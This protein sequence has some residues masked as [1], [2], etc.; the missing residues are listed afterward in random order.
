[1]T[2]RYRFAR[3]QDI[4]GLAA[5]RVL[6]DLQK[7]SLPVLSTSFGSGRGAWGASPTRDPTSRPHSRQKA[8]PGTPGVWQT[9]RGAA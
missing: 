4:G 1:M 9:G 3:Q 8:S 7:N 6:T 2:T 5:Y